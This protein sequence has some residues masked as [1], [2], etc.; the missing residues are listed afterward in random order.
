MSGHDISDGGLILC[1]LEMAFAGIC[2]ITVNIPTPAGFNQPLGLLFAEELGW[3]LEV[4]YYY[5][6]FTCW[7]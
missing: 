6:M 3:V 5:T 2:G 1:L 7:V 4:K